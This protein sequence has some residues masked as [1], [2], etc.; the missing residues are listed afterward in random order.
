MAKPLNEPKK[1][2]IS[3]SVQATLPTQP[4]HKAQM[5]PEHRKEN[6]RKQ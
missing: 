6:V 3:T 2:Q 4:K 1:K 5:E